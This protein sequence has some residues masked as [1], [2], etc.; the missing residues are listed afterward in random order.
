[1]IDQYFPYG[2]V[3]IADEELHLNT[4]Y[5]LQPPKWANDELIMAFCRW[6]CIENTS[7]QLVGVV[8]AQPIVR[9]GP[10]QRLAERIKSR[11]TDLGH[12]ADTLLLPVN[13]G[14]AQWCCIDADVRLKWILFN[15]SLNGRS[16]LGR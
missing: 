14:N 5:S 16:Y 8:S 15:T 3:A 12:N 1:M 2:T 13:F 6:L 10:T 9:N 4:M 11:A 7:V